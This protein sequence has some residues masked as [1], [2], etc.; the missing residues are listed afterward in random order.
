M[1]LHRR[2]RHDALVGVLQVQANLGGL[3]G[4]CLEQE[5]A[6]DDLKTVGDAMLHLLHQHLLLPEQI[7]FFP[8]GISALGYIFYRQQ[9]GSGRAVLVEHLSR[10]EEHHAAADGWEFVLNLI[11]LDGAVF[12]DHIFEDNPQSRN[13][14]LPIAQQ[15]ELSALRVARLHR[16]SPVKGS[17]RGNDPQV[18]I[19]NDKRLPNAQRW[20]P[21]RYAHAPRRPKGCDRPRGKIPLYLRLGCYPSRSIRRGPSHQPKPTN[22]H[23]EE[24]I[25]LSNGSNQGGD[26]GR[27]NSRSLNSCASL[28]KRTSNRHGWLTVSSWMAWR[29]QCVHGRQ[30]PQ[31]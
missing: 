3:H 6:C 4:S 18:S 8:L 19:E 25:P 15:V 26:D 1:L 31:P 27:R 2:H 7:V 28:R 9:E 20:P 13:V 10:V 24:L 16:E 23:V 12:R 29:R 17:T 14:P 5:N 11:G 30:Y 21:P 22:S